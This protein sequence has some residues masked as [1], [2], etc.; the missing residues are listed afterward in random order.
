MRNRRLL[1][2]PVL[3]AALTCGGPNT[4]NPSSVTTSCI[5]TTPSVLVNAGETLRLKFTV[6]QTSAT[7]LLSYELDGLP[8]PLVPGPSLPCQLFDGERFLATDASCRGHWQSATASVRL[9]TAPQID[10][11]T[12]AA[13]TIAGRVDFVIT[14]GS[15]AFDG[16]GTVSVGRTIMTDTGPNVIYVAAGAASPLELISRSCR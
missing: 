11:S 7:D 15:W 3:A 16:K 8:N 2:L 6:P 14:G 13:G 12:V 9:P 4:T 10:F 5:V 1:F